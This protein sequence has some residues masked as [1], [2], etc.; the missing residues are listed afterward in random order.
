MLKHFD[1]LLALIKKEFLAIWR[2]PKSRAIIIVP[3]FLQLLV[4]ATAITMEIKNI[5]MLVVDYSQTQESREL[6]AGFE[7]SAWFG[8]IHRSNNIE[9]IKTDIETQKIGAA[10]IISSDFARN[11]KKNQPA[12]IQL[13]LD[14]RSTIIA[15]SMNGYVAQIAAAYS[16]KLAKK[17]NVNGAQISIEV[18]NWFNPNA[19]YIWYLLT[20]L[21]VMLA[22]IVTLILTA[23]SVARERELGTFEQL[24]V[25]PYTAFEILLGKTIPPLL[26]SLTILSGMTFI[27][28]T[29]FGVPFT[30]SFLLFLCSAFIALLSFVGVGVF[31]SS[32]SKNQ[33]QAI[34]LVF[35]FMMPAILLSGFIS[36]IDD[37]P[38][39]LQYLTYIDPIRF[40]M[41]IGRGMFLKGMQFKDV[42]A[43]LIPLGLIALTTLTLAARSFK[44]NLE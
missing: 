6:A 4:F 36:P 13:I 41:N 23:L 18:R 25:S 3:P 44:R 31:I 26:L 19:T 24:I 35:T 38:E 11:I 17:D 16:Q 43:N 5:D 22:M 7:N 10:I 42:F 30:G 34:L 32:I 9:D 29:F 14:G 33:Q 39:V 15:K 28:I 8:K 21:I 20:A 40:F 1:R 2:D 37:M 27:V 12:N